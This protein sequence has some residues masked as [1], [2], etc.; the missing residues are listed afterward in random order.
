AEDAGPDR[1]RPGDRRLTG[2]ADPRGRGRRS[3]APAPDGE[4][5][6]RRRLPRGAA[7]G[8]VGG[9]PALP[10]RQV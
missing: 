1:L 6:A 8:A 9:H 10:Q 5:G 7:P 4:A 2:L 3:P